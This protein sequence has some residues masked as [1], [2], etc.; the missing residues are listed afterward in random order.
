MPDNP[1]PHDMVLSVEDLPH[2]LLELLWVRQAY[3]LQPRGEDLPPL[4]TVPPLQLLQ[5]PS[6]ATRQEWTSAWPSMW[7][8]ALQHAGREHDPASHDRL[9]RTA[10]GSR[11]RRE[12][13][14]AIVGPTWR[15][16]SDPTRSRTGPT[17][18]GLVQSIKGK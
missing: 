9:R 18:N 1:W 3:D 17:R 11:E 16:Q 2:A 15:E 5:P 7:T 6:D 14:Q 10:N 13:L 12:L 4:L 8:A